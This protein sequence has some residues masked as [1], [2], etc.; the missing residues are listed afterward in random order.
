M[1]SPLII[2]LILISSIAYSQVPHQ[3]EAGD[4]VSASKMNENFEYASKRLYLKNNNSIIGEIICDNQ[5]C[6]AITDKGYLILGLNNIPIF[7]GSIT[8]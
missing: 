6:L 2:S 1:K 5:E 7:S 3:F 8:M 4:T